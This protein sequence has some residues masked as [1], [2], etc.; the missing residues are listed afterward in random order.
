VLALA[1]TFVG[2]VGRPTRIGKVATDCAPRVAVP[3]V[4]AIGAE[5][6]N[7]I[8]GVATSNAPART[9]TETSAVPN[10]LA[11]CVIAPPDSGAAYGWNRDGRG[12]RT[13]YIQA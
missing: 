6:A 11:R 4:G 5:A 1:T 13:I 10:A 3:I 9:A 8:F 7:A 2:A 12:V